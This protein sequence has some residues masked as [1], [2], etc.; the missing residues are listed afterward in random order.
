V[1]AIEGDA[2]GQGGEHGLFHSF[3]GGGVPHARM[4]FGGR[5]S[6]KQAYKLG[7]RVLHIDGLHQFDP[8]SGHSDV[9]G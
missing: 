2:A 4:V 1:P 6:C 8:C 9:L 5:L 3:E 7:Q